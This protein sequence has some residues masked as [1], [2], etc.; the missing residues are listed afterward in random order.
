MNIFDSFQLKF[1]KTKKKCQNMNIFDSCHPKFLKN[2][3]K[4]VKKW[5][6]LTAVNSSSYKNK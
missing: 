2:Q 3:A 6:F 4:N 5:P 1:L